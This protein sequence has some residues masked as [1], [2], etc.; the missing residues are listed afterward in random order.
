MSIIGKPYH[1]PKKRR[2][3]RII[4]FLVLFIIIAAYAV[5]EKI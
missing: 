3:S 2:A 5:M 4:G 1:L